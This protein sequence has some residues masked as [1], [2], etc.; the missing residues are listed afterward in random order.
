MLVLV[1]ASK[2]FSQRSKNSSN[3]KKDHIVELMQRQKLSSESLKR[4]QACMR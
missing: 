1:L 2:P 3:Y 4:I